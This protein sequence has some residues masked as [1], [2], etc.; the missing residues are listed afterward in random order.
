VGTREL[1][2]S[3]TRR[4]LADAAIRL[5]AEQGFANVT[6]AD[7][8]AEAG[9]SRRTA[10]RYFPSKDDLVMQHPAE[11]LLVFDESVEANAHLALGSRIRHASFAVAAHIEADPV[12]VRQLFGLAFAHP[13][14]AGR[15]AASSATWIERMAVEIGRDLPDETEAQLLA[16]AVMGIIN[17]VCEIWATTDQ[18]MVPLLDRGLALVA[19]RLD[20]NPR[21]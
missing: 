7:V 1:K 13:S 18:P 15:Y 2:K 10:F 5:F 8:A 20:H 9:V 16:A 11:W 21:V 3:Q 6:M 12:P 4:A 19:G 14:I 17:A